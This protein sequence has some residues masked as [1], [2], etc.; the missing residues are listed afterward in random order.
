L[1]WHSDIGLFLRNRRGVS[2]N[3]TPRRLFMMQPFGR[4]FFLWLLP[5]AL[6]FAANQSHA[7]RYL[8]SDE[9]RKLCFPQADR[10]EERVHEF[11]DEEKKTIAKKCGSPV[12]LRGQ[13]Y[14]VAHQ[15]TNIVGVIVADHVLGK[16]EIIDY[17]VAISLDGKVRQVEILE[18][19]E[20]HGYEIRSDKW[21]DQFKE[22][23][24]KDKLRLNG[25]IYN[26]S[27]ATISC[28]NVT[29]GVKRVLATF[30]LVLRPALPA[31]SVPDKSTPPK[32]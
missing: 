9:A 5:V 32:N 1:E 27:G 18:Y 16:H 17:A 14:W 13:R 24:T 6:L 8:T 26:I 31:A 10:F 25:D 7:E 29:E 30:D 19:R 11:T 20:S 15:G 28:R 23:S 3:R 4:R 22:K 12:R 21:R 2:G